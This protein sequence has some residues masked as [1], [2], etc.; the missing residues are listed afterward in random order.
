MGVIYTHPHV[1]THHKGLGRR[2]IQKICLFR[3][4]WDTDPD[5]DRNLLG[6]VL[7]S[8]FFCQLPTV[9]RGFAL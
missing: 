9:C 3:R 6:S 7:E 1:Y 4:T 2:L 5:T 8:L